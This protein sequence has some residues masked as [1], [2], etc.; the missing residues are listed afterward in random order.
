[1]LQP[2]VL[3]SPVS[4][5]S[6]PSAASAGLPPLDSQAFLKLLVTQLQHQDPLS[7]ADPGETVQQLAALT[8]VSSLQEIS[9]LL[10]QLLGKGSSYDPAAWLGRSA[11]VPSSKALPR[12][13]GSYAGEVLVDGPTELDITFTDANGVVVHTEHHV[14]AAKGAI[15]FNWEGRVNGE[16]VKGPLTISV[17]AR[18]G[19]P[20]SVGVWTTV[21]SVR[22]PGGS[23]ALVETPLGSFTPDVV[24]DLQ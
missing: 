18:G 16:A 24:I 5:S 19:M 14:S 21:T 13:D 10:R 15:S 6:A 2:N 12:E 9:A 20:A 11:L 3:Q 4:P 1:M 8:Q 22:G 7:P 17:A 23:S